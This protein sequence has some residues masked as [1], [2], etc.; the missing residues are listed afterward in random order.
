[1]CMKRTRRGNANVKVL[2]NH[3][4]NVIGVGVELTR[5]TTIAGDIIYAVVITN[6][7]TGYHYRILTFN[8]IQ[9]AFNKYKE[10]VA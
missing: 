7:N 1:M 3:R 9:G 4:N 6:L 10:A 2:K 8:G 5:K